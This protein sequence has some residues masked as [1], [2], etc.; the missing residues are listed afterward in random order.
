MCWAEETGGVAEASAG[1]IQVVAVAEA[2]ADLAVEIPAAVE[3]PAT[4][5]WDG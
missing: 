3:P 5:K 4:G 2:L 1:M